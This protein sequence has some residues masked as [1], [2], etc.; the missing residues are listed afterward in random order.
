MISFYC[1]SGSLLRFLA[2]FTG[3]RFIIPSL[4]FYF[5]YAL[6]VGLNYK[7]D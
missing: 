3:V 1:L 7:I 4:L 5:F 6:K 2:E